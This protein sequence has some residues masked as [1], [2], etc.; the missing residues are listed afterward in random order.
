MAKD[1]RSF[2]APHGHRRAG[3][4]RNLEKKQG[5]IHGSV[6]GHWAMTRAATVPEPVPAAPAAQQALHDALYRG[7][8]QGNDLRRHG[9]HDDDQDHQDDAHRLVESIHR[10]LGSV[11]RV[12]GVGYPHH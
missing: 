11:F 4:V 1:S 5:R 8:G 12:G 3:A 2:V 7:I 10:N 6:R 9:A